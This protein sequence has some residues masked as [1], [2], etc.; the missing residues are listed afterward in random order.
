[1]FI[2]T[3]FEDLRREKGIKK[4]FLAEKLHRT[5]TIFQDWKAGK[6]KPS[7]EQLTIISRELGTTPEY[8]TGET[9]EKS[10]RDKRELSK[11]EIKYAFFGGD[12]GI[13]T[14]DDLADVQKLV[15]IVIER[16]KRSENR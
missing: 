1:L 12:A 5:P 3:R 2:F 10:P 15:Q 4:T 8:L 13:M 16:R 11:E 9:N 14:D 6:S 7:Y